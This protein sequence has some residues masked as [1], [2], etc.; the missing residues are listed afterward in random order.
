L[1]PVTITGI[2]GTNINY[3]GGAGSQFILLSSGDLTT[4]SSAW[5]RLFTNTTTPG[6]FIIPPVG[7][8]NQLFY[9]IKSE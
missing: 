2:S 9:R 1:L 4:I 8:T 7:S 5:T 3:T 6:L